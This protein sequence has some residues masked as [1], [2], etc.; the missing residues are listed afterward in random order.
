MQANADPQAK[1]VRRARL[2]GLGWILALSLAVNTLFLAGPIYMMQVYDRVLPSGDVATL[3]GLTLILVIV[4]AAFAIF[5]ILRQK[6]AALHAEELCAGLETRAFAL[7]VAAAAD[8]ALDARATAPEDVETVRGFL[9]APAMMALYDSP[10]MPMY[11]LAIVLLHPLLGAVV[12]ACGVV[13]AIL[14]IV[15]ERTSRAHMAKAQMGL[16]AS[17]RILAG[18]RRDA[19]TLKANAMIASVAAHWRDSQEEPRAALLDGQARISVFGSATKTLRL[20]IQSLVLAVGAWL[21]VNGNL[22]AGAMIAASVVFARAIAPLE[23]L[24]GSW[25]LVLRAREAW[26][27]IAQWEREPGDEDKFV[28]PAP[29]S[30]VE[31]LRLNVRAPG[32]ER[33]LVRDVT[34]DL[35]PGDVLAI[36]GASGA[37]KSTLARAFAGVW[38]KSSGAL[39]LDGADLAQ[40]PSA[41]LR[42]HIGYLGQNVDS[43]EGT[44]AQIIARFDRSVDDSL[45]LAAAVAAGIH[46]FI[47]SLPQGYDT[48]LGPGGVQLSGGQRQR[49]GLARALLGD[50]FLVVLDEPTAHL[51]DAGRSAVGQII[52]ARRKAGKVTVLTAHD[53]RALAIAT[54]IL[55]L[56]EG[57]MTMSGP[58]D[59]VLARLRSVSDGSAA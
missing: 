26:S 40:W 8:G 39:R 32:Q 1:P 48:P 37:G 51:D 17:G 45:V 21:V 43:L 14:A 58:R 31:A 42:A 34:I 29:K 46:T 44:P 28:L 41:Q 15:N 54:K 2:E 9:N 5:D 16:Q 47:L 19:E 11:F 52:Q 23:Q 55:V 56:E 38:P 18:A 59:A 57:R 20:F 50:P 27:R 33:D 4:Y 22:S 10:A 36:L 30:R 24:L 12:L 49:L 6:L 35:G 3:F 7:S 25:R 53:A 13:L